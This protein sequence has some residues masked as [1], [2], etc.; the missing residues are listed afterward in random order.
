SSVGRNFGTTRHES[1]CRNSAVIDDEQLVLDMIVDEKEVS[2][3]VVVKK[4]HNIIYC[5]LDDDWY[6]LKACA[7]FVTPENKMTKRIRHNFIALD[8]PTRELL[9]EKNHALEDMV[10]AMFLSIWGKAFISAT[11]LLDKIP[12][13]ENKIVLMN[14]GW[15]ENYLIM[16]FMV[17]L[18][19]KL[20]DHLESMTKLSKIRDNEMIMISKMRD[21]INLRKK[22]LN[23]EEANGKLE[24]H[25]E[26]MTKLSKIRDNEMIMISKMRDNI[27]LRKKRLNIEEANG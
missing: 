5:T 13:K 16:V 15:E 7:L 14:Y 26:S 18:C 2:R 10:N 11:Y 25:L 27:N 1:S 4:L 23:I 3:L 12:C 22:R 17:S 6:R 24:D 8:T 9:K 21:N 19:M 20:E